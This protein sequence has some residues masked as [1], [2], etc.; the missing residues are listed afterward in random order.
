MSEESN[1]LA[2]EAADASPPVEPSDGLGE[3]AAE[4]EADPIAELREALLA[5]LSH[6]MSRNSD[7]PAVRDSIR[8]IQS[9]ARSETA[10]MRVFT[11]QILQDVSVTNKLLRLINTAFYSSVGGGTITTV[12]RAIAL[13]GFSP[14][15]MLAGSVMLFDKLPKGPH[16]EKMREEF[17]QSLMA[18]IIANEFCPMR[19]MEENAYISALFQNLGR[20]LGQLHLQ[21]EIA[22]V[23]A[24][25]IAADVADNDRETRA[26]IERETMGLTLDEL[27]VEIGQ[28][29]G[30]P[31]GLIHSLRPLVP[32]DP[33]K[34]AGEKE[35]LRM[36]VTGANQLA[37]DLLRL[38]GP[39]RLAAAERFHA[40][41]GIPLQ[42]KLEDMEALV[43]RVNQKW[44]D[45]AKALG[46]PR[47]GA[48][49]AAKPTHTPT[50]LS[51]PMKP[52]VRGATPPAAAEAQAAKTAATPAAAP[53]ATKAAKA[54]PKNV[55]AVNTDA[56]SRGIEAISQA[57]MSDQP[58]TEVLKQVMQVMCDALQLQRAIMCLRDPAGGSLQGV[59]GQG[60]GGIACAAKFRIAL[61]PPSDLFGLLCVKGADTL[62]SDASDPVIAQRLPAWFKQ[63]VAAPT[64]LL[65]PLAVQGRTT[66][67]L[68]GDRAQAGSLVVDEAAFSL[69][70]TLRNQLVITM[71]LRG[72][73]G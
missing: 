18:A 63:H 14:V 31:E 6:K 9:V 54:A 19:Q 59:L 70:K 27:T 52:A 64:F 38:P 47:P 71:R 34:P 5:Q 48:K 55:A 11:D 67:L 39:Q 12:S 66:G 25:H 35:Y 17:S 36:V 43:E 28:Q 20:M 68:Y 33:E 13:M 65:L 44:F 50:P 45:V 4:A 42:L 23:D 30:W 46:L 24:A 1:V 8:T 26:R 69:L 7:F 3:V 16:A 73:T 58:L 29:W 22:R 40:Q 61:E 57:A 62:I 37:R 32:E 72:T 49:V 15:G 53:P 60:Q 2:A 21:D 51:G 41:W 10:H 56:L